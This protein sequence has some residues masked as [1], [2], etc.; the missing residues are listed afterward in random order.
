MSTRIKKPTTIVGIA[1]V[2]ALIIALVFYVFLRRP[3]EE[4]SMYAVT[5]LRQRGFQSV[6]VLKGGFPE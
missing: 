3:A 1:V 2:G 4:T 6:S 5:L